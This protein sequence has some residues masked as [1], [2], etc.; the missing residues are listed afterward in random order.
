MF[1]ADETDID[2]KT[3]TDEETKD[4]STDEENNASADTEISDK[5]IEDKSDLS[6]DSAKQNSKNG[7]NL[8]VDNDKKQN[9][10]KGN[11][12]ET[13]KGF[14]IA[15][16]GAIMVGSATS[17]ISKFVKSYKNNK[18]DKPNTDLLHSEEQNSET[19]NPNGPKK[20]EKDD[21]SSEK[22]KVGVCLI[23]IKV[24]AA[25]IFTWAV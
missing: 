12:V 14:A 10:K 1:D 16:T 13:V 20:R 4:D 25:T 17:V 8:S 18:K 19:D 11:G 3:T 22:E 5:D 2:T 23:L 15:G 24:F 9:V 21:E 6:E 7:V